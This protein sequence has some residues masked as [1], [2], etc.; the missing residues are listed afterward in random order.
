MEASRVR[1]RPSASRVRTRPSK[2]LAGK[3]SKDEAFEEHH[4]LIIEYAR[5]TDIKPLIE[6]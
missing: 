2:L 6:P 5:C 3:Q 4:A 1:T